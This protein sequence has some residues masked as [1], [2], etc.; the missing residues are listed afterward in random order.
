MDEMKR[1]VFLLHKWSIMKVKVMNPCKVGFNIYIETR[2]S[3]AFQGEVSAESEGK[4]VGH[5][6]DTCEA[7]LRLQRLLL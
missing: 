3:P 6:H 7:Y 5:D 4:R 2:V 1:K